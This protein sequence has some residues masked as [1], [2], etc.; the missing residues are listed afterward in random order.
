MKQGKLWDLTCDAA[1]AGDGP[2][3]PRRGFETVDRDGSRITTGREAVSSCAMA[4]A[5]KHEAAEVGAEILKKGGNAIDAAVAMGFVLS[6]TEPFTSGPG[7]G[8]MAIIRMAD[9]EAVFVDFREKAPAAASHRLFMKADGTA[10]QEAFDSGGMACCVPGD[11]AGLLYMLE[12]YG[13]MDRGEVLEPAIRIASEGF[14]VSSYCAEAIA[15]AYG[16]CEQFPEMQKL[17]WDKNGQAYKAGDILVNPDLAGTLQKIAEEGAAGFYT[18]E[19][20]EAIVSCVGRYGGMISRKDLE[21]Y[22]PDISRPVTG[23]Y[24]GYSVISSPPPSSG[25]ST[26]IEILNILENF[27]VGAMEINSAEYVH[28]FTEA[29][30]LGY[31]DRARYLADP[32]F[33]KVPLAELTDKAFAAGRAALIDRNSAQEYGCGDLFGAEHT[34]TT[35]YS[36]ADA[37]G[38]CV[39]VTKTINGY[40]GSGVVVDGWGFVMNNS[41]GDFSP[42]PLSVNRVEPGKKPLS[43]MSPTVVLHQDGTPFMVLGSPGGSR[44]FATVLQVISRVIDHHMGLH[45]AVCVPRIWNTGA[46]NDLTY[47]EPLKGYETYAL[48][49]ETIR[50]LTEMGHNKIGRISSGA[51]QAVMFMEDGK[52]YGTADPRQDGKAVGI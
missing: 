22:R 14:V 15:E 28:L 27:N 7:G 49:G 10:D 1:A 11:V 52:L 9:G 4:S 6:V 30:K 50:R 36:V 24:R 3:K 19:I 18:G 38:N 8:G 33:E 44:I 12:H 41:M 13:T 29:F 2:V 21:N 35:H 39:S 34:D 23:T 20:V 31:A 5:S 26:M 40:F 47:E 45:D 32:D 43:S 25:G 37:E 17:Y 46:S 51:V 48:T 16:L 42:D